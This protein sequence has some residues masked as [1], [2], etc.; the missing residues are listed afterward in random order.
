ME[1]LEEMTEGEKTAVTFDAESKIWGKY[2]KFCD[3]NAMKY[4]P[5]L[6][7]IIEDFLKHEG[8]IK[9]EN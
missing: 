5:K 2:T 4:G 8:V 6:N 3:E 9:N 7:K 1:K